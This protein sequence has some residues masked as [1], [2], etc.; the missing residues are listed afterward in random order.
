MDRLIVE[1]DPAQPDLNNRMAQMLDN[2][3]VTRKYLTY[4]QILMLGLKTE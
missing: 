2:G 4:L 1:I 3:G